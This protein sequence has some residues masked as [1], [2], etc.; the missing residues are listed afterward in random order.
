MNLNEL[1]CPDCDVRMT[2][3]YDTDDSYG[4]H[5]CFKCQFFHKLQNPEEFESNGI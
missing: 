4:S 2:V 3:I 5:A 1:K